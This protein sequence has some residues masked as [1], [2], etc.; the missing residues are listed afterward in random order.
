MCI[1]DRILGWALKL[2]PMIRL[3][4]YKYRRLE[5]K[6]TA[7]GLDMTPQVYTCLLYTS[8]CV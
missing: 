3:D 6:L 5:T 8:R 2:A 4:E 7:A 1:R